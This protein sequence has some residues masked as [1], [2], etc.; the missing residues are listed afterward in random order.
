MQG[1]EEMQILLGNKNLYTNYK[2]NDIF[3]N[4]TFKY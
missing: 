3:L 2:E 1:R 4:I